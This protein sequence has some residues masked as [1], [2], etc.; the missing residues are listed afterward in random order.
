MRKDTDSPVVRWVQLARRCGCGGVPF[1]YSVLNE[2]ITNAVRMAARSFEWQEGDLS[3]VLAEAGRG[4]YGT[5][6]QLYATA[7]AAGNRS[8][9]LEYERHVNRK[10]I[11][12]D[13]V[14]H[15]GYTSRKRD[16]IAEGT[17]FR[18]DGDLVTVT[19]FA[20]DGAAI[21]CSYAN[22]DESRRS[23]H[24]L[25]IKRRYRITVEDVKE[26]RKKAKSL[27]NKILGGSAK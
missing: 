20:D 16:R 2:Q 19:S 12:V 9:C 5:T 11:L 6:E 18:W 1:S 14:I 26:A 27:A 21:A 8:F 23:G 25:K 17:R 7:V 4:L 13:N 22:E 24:R 10:P 3:A 15:H